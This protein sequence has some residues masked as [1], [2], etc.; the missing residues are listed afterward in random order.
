ML[1]LILLVMWS[2]EMYLECYK[3][4]SKLFTRS[5][6]LKNVGILLC[7]SLTYKF[8]LL[9]FK[10]VVVVVVLFFACLVAAKCLVK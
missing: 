1:L 9:G 7:S 10:F 6:G 4:V 8:L 3:F 2:T 5:S